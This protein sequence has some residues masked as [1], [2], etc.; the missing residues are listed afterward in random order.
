M[1]GHVLAPGIN[2][3]VEVGRL[4]GALELIEA[5]SAA[6]V[7]PGRESFNMLIKGY[8]ALGD[9]ESA[10]QVGAILQSLLR[11]QA[12]RFSIFAVRTR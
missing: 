3:H 12:A 8:T 4:K 5:M 6:G 1:P 9:M 7:R 11:Y 10:R 2:A